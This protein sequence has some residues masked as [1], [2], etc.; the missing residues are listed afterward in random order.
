MSAAFVY[1]FVKRPVYQLLAV[2]ER[3]LYT[4]AKA[5]L[6]EIKEPFNI[7]AAAAAAAFLLSERKFG[8]QQLTDVTSAT[9][10]YILYDQ[11]AASSASNALS[12]RH[13]ILTS[14]IYNLPRTRN[15]II[16]K[17]FSRGYICK[18]SETTDIYSL[19]LKIVSFIITSI[20]SQAELH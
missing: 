1:T 20:F 7:P 12:S 6:V 5:Q 14:N 18:L 13:P 2:R 4:R 11:S 9:I 10:L 8:K 3:S 16:I 17:V 19:T 15:P